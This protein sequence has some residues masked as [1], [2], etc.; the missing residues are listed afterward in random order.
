MEGIGVRDVQD[1]FSPA[2][3][4]RDPE[5]FAGRRKEIE[6]G[7]EA[8][9]NEGSFLVVHG[10]RGVGK[11]SIARQLEAIAEGNDTLPNMMGLDRII[12]RDG[13]NYKVQ[14][15]SCD[16]FVR[17]ITDLI[18]RILFSDDENESL[19]SLTNTGERKISEIKNI[20]QGSGKLNLPGIGGLSGGGSTETTFITESSDNI[21][22]NF[23]EVLNLL[24]KDLYSVYNGVL[25][26]IDEFD[27]IENKEGFSSIVKTCSSDF[28]KFGIVG[29]ANNIGELIRDHESIGRQIDE[30]EVKTM[31]DSELVKIIN[32]AEHKVNNRIYFTRDAKSEIAS[33]SEGFPY[34]THLIGQEAMMESFKRGR[35]EINMENINKINN[36]ISKGKLSTNYEGLYH[37]SVKQ[38]E[39]R[40]ILLKL[41]AEEDS[42]EI[43]T[44]RVYEEAKEMG[45]SNPSQ[46]M[47]EL[48][49]GEDGSGVLKKV[50][51]RY[52]RFTDPVFKVY[53]RKRGWKF[54]HNE[55]G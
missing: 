37:D 13:F 30:V 23:R 1:A 10:L 16:E 52:Y 42:D 8:L 39:H 33:M 27:A 28:I 29:I 50:R 14:Y 22:Q 6:D 18:E 49:G 43:H 25:I 38:S 53:A 5:M 35:S 46:L 20:M 47:K 55:D 31:D 44:E 3:E 26:L 40:E 54:G 15:V 45:M 12:P 11:T 17:D 36:Q 4:I 7:I 48:T 2:Q 19:F 51:P 41:F 24:K 21:V 9:L 32:N 34:F